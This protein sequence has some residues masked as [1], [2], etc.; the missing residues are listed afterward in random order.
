MSVE[1][2]SLLGVLGVALIS[3]IWWQLNARLAKEERNFDRR[4]TELRDQLMELQQTVEASAIAVVAERVKRLELDFGAL[5]TWKNVILP[6]H[7][8][9][10]FATFMD[11]VRWRLEKLEKFANGALK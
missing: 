3:T 6:Q 2:I 10:R 4:L 7:L 5:H 11:Q 8:D 1:W 9:Q